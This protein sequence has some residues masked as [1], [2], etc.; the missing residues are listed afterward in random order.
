[1][2]STTDSAEGRAERERRQRGDDE[3]LSLRE[4]Q[5]RQVV[6]WAPNGMI[7][8]NGEG[9]IVLVN[10]QAE[11]DF[12][13]SREE[14]VGQPMDVLVPERFRAHHPAYRDQFLTAPAPRPMGKGRELFGR[15]R[16]GSEFPVEIGLN[17][18][19]T[20]DGVA[21][22]ASLVDITERRHAQQSLETA[23]QEKIVLLNEI[24]HRVK[25]NLQLVSSLLNLQAAQAED[26]HIR[27]ILTESQ[28]RVKAMALTHQ[29]LYE[30]KDFSRVELGEYLG[31]LT[32]LLLGSYQGVGE[33]V[34]LKLELGDG[35]YILDLK[36][37]V[38]CGLLVNELVTNAFV[39]AFPGDRRGVILVRLERAEGDLRLTIADDGIGLGPEFSLE[40][41]KTLGLQLASLFADQLQGALTI[42]RRS[43]TTVSLRFPASPA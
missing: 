10:A 40:A 29:L 33:R 26:P 30:T 9:L 7:L 41:A 24:Q 38:P 20:D 37:A 23:L 22:L 12:G 3:R 2:D 39:H 19:K 21:A 35:V 28:N 31:R 13:Y 14:L 25:S 17:P 5:F 43:G 15:R 34:Q 4:E 11:R 6:E 8:V 42:E 1:M 16:D 32:R 18:I 36:R 27:A